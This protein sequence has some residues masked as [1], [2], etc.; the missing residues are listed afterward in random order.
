MA[1]AVRYSEYGAPEVLH[2]VEVEIPV[3]GPGEVLIEVRAAG[4]NPI[5]WKIRQG[6]RGNDPLP[7]PRGVGFDASGVVLEVGS[8]VTS[9]KP[10]DA[11][12]GS[13]VNGAY[14]SHVVAAVDR[15]TL[16]PASLGWEQAAGFGV[17]GGTA[18]QALKSLRV[19]A[20]ETVVVHG[21]SGA[22]GQ[23][24]V[25][26][27]R[28]WGATVIGTASE[29]NHAR[30]SELGAIPVAYGEGLLERIRQVAP[31]GVD[32]VLDCAGTEEALTVSLA[33]VADR[34]RI[35]TIVVTDQAVD[36]GIQ[37]WTSSMPQYFTE[38]LHRL[39][40]EAIPYLAELAERGE[41]EVEIAGRYPLELA[42][43]AHRRSETGHVRGKLVL[44]P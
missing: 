39:R 4:V 16:K 42:A 22:V 41:F 21:A 5:D 27:A 36:A 8:G 10:G 28:L 25:Q 23:V 24:A 13:G 20:G 34:Q 17:P 33:L 30:L 7:A 6:L 12:I 31:G 11:V 43:E 37:V 29:A 14:A 32:A 40:T 3:P 1:R 15:F 19:S 18:Y 35:G 38:E 2:V 26:L 9:L 44:V